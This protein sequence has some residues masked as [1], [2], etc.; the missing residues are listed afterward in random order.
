MFDYVV[1]V[2]LIVVVI[3]IIQMD[4]HI[5][6]KSRQ[7]WNRRIGIFI[8]D[9]KHNQQKQVK[10]AMVDHDPYIIL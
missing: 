9:T 4:K 1:G 10:P 2:L 8:Y 3:F 7:K 5:M 6:D